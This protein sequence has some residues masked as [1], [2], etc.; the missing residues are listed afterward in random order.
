MGVV[1]YKQNK[2]Q[3]PKI[4]RTLLI[5]MTLI[6][7]TASLSQFQDLRLFNFVRDSAKEYNYE[8]NQFNKIQ[9]HRKTGKITFNASKNKTGETYIVIIG[10]S[11]NKNH[12][13][14]YNYFRNTT[15]RLSKLKRSKKIIVFNNA[16][17]NHVHTVEVLSLS[18]TEASQY[19]KK[20]YY[21]SLSII[22]ILKKAG[23]KTY[24][25]TNQH[26]YGEYDNMISV[27]AS[28]A[29]H[30]ITMNNTLGLHIAHQNF[31][32]VLLNKVGEI[33][34]KKS[35]KNRVLFVHLMGSH[36]KYNL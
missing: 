15:P 22:E 17:S 8:V 2:L 16:Y 20:E 36:G 25:L 29:D 30:L 6:F 21:D 27:L 28:S 4:S 5:F 14:L 34:K 35:K 12:M 32:D 18:L 26:L 19:N 7:L 13:G 1:L 10:E 23:F 31:D 3:P 9:K 33:L 11:L 24:W